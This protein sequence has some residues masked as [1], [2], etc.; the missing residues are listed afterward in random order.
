MLHHL[1][2]GDKEK[3]LCEVRRVLQ[4]GGS[5]HLLDFGGPES[6]RDGFLARWR[7]SSNRL[8]DNSEG[9]VLNL[10][11]QAGF[12]EPKRVGQG[13][14]LFGRITYYYQAAAPVSEASTA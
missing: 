5:F 8:K 13:A 14:M 7:H 12:A 4:P 10:L 11:R 6:S 1:Q 9:R 3:T 2:P